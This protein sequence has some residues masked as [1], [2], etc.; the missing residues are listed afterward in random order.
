MVYEK[1]IIYVEQKLDEPF[2][3][4]HLATLTKLNDFIK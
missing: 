1:P 3:C 4:I 2:Y